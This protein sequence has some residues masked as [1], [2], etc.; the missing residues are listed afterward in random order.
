[1]YLP[2]VPKSNNVIPNSERCSCGSSEKHDGGSC[3]N[4]SR[5]HHPPNH[6]LM[7]AYPA[8]T[9]RSKLSLVC[10]W[11]YIFLHTLQILEKFYS[12]QLNIFL[13]INIYASRYMHYQFILAY[14]NPLPALLISI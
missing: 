13:Y 5:Y 12:I 10:T 14:N 4:G 11:I 6:R 2:Q 7:T 9:Q 8:A 3:V 1:M